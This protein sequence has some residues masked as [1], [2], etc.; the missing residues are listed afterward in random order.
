MPT[1]PISESAQGILQ[2][3]VLKADPEGWAEE[4]AERKLWDATHMD[5]LDPT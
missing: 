5:C 2:E 3:R 1:I 4:L